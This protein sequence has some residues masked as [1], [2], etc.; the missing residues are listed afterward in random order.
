MNLDYSEMQPTV[1]CAKA[2]YT[3]YQMFFMKNGHMSY[4]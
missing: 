1:P 2:C 4:A 3:P